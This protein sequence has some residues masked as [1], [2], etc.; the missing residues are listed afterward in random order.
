MTQ[1]ESLWNP[2]MSFGILHIDEHHKHLLNLLIEAKQILDGE[3][4]KIA[5]KNVISAL[6][7]YTKY[8]FTAEERL[9]LEYKYP[10][11]AEHTEEHQ[12][13][14]SILEDTFIRVHDKN[15][16]LPHE[17]YQFLKNW[18]VE[19]ILKKDTLIGQYVQS[20]KKS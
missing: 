16:N 20:Q 13:F 15:L 14:L 17:L 19:H 1:A 3:K 12:K 9:M 4:D 18:Y 2:K 7:G 8:H 5:L 11:L 10:Y 6:V